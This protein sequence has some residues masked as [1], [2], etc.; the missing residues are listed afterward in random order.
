MH[1]SHLHG[2]S[3]LPEVEQVL[4]VVLVEIAVKL[5]LPRQVNLL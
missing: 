4:E 1:S 2:A 3:F 5:P